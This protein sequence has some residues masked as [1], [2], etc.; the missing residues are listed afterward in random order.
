MALSSLRYAVEAVRNSFFSRLRSRKR[1]PAPGMASFEDA[2]SVWPRA[3]SVP[4]AE[5]F[6]RLVELLENRLRFV[7]DSSA[8]QILQRLDRISQSFV[9]DP[10]LVPFLDVELAELLGLPEMALLPFGSV[11]PSRGRRAGS[12]Q[13]D[14]LLAAPGHPGVRSRSSSEVCSTR[15]RYRADCSARASRRWLS[16]R[17]S[18]Q[19]WSSAITAS[20]SPAS[21][22][23]RSMATSSP[24]PC[25][26]RCPAISTR[27]QTLGRSASSTMGE[28]KRIA[29]RKWVGAIRG[30]RQ[31]LPDH[32]AGA[33]MLGEDRG[34]VT[35]G[36]DPERRCRRPC[37]G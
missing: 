37:R 33:L 29:V 12:A 30:V 3:S 19:C 31:Q 9:E 7:S 18:S 24:A 34:E 2:A 13:P 35:A 28:K 14:G 16:A 15:R 26:A 8:E 17:F 5:R 25:R 1:M 20:S 36:D 11:A 4:L 22:T 27:P 32:P 23:T 10:Q 21:A 6:S